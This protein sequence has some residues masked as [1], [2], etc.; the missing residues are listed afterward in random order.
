MYGANLYPSNGNST[1]RSVAVMRTMSSQ[2][3]PNLYYYRVDVYN[4]TVFRINLRYNDLA[5]VKGSSSGLNYSPASD[6]YM[7]KVSSKMDVTNHFTFN[8]KQYVAYY[9]KKEKQ[10]IIEEIIE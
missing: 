3:G 6:A 9:E 5:I 1:P 10:Y 7:E 4:E 8:S 2:N